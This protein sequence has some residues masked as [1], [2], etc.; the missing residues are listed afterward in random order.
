[1]SRIP[2]PPVLSTAV[3][4]IGVIGSFLVTVASFAVIVGPVTSFTVTG[5]FT[6]S[7]DPSG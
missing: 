1:M 7:L 6:V 2:T 4:G 5:T 3:T